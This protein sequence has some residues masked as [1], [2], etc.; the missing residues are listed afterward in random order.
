[1]SGF[2]TQG[3]QKETK[4]AEQLHTDCDACMCDVMLD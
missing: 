2:I 3:K 1:M 4:H